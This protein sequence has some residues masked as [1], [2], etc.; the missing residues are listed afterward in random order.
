MAQRGPQCDPHRG[1]VYMP[2]YSVTVAKQRAFGIVSTQTVY[3]SSR[4]KENDLRICSHLV[5]HSTP[6]SKALCKTPRSERNLYRQMWT[7]DFKTIKNYLQ[8]K[9]GYV[10]YYL[11]MLVQH[12]A[13]LKQ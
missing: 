3:S 13:L 11:Y 7:K 4:S 5:I 12:T 2:F 8:K 6:T 9:K 1:Q 10:K